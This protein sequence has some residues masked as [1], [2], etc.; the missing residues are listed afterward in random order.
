M[1]PKAVNSMSDTFIGALQGDKLSL[2]NFVA[3][4]TTLANTFSDRDQ[5]LGDLIDSISKVTS[6]LANRSG[7]LDTLL[8]QTRVL[9]EGLSAQGA[10]LKDATDRISNS[11]NDLVNLL[12]TITPTIKAAQDST[13]KALNLLIA[14]GPKLDQAALDGP[15]VLTD[16]AR[17][18]SEG[19]YL[20][21]EP[22]LLDLSLW[23]V[24]L[25]RGLFD[26]IG[27]SGHSEVCR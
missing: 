5:I 1:D 6:G 15:R 4:A 19:A 12:S 9:I 21:V 3:Q 27:G 24:L 18:T 10:S 22:C 8:A 13:T 7:Q 20:G 14:T 16:L 26:Q 11:S 2:S 23:G 17:V 25:P